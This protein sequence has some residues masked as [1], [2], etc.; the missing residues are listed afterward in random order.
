M[1]K[2]LTFFLRVVAKDNREED[3]TAPP[4]DEIEVK[5]ATAKTLDGLGEDGKLA[6]GVAEGGA[7]RGGL[8][9]GQG[10]LCV[11]PG[12][13]RKVEPGWDRE[14]QWDPTDATS[15]AKHPGCRGTQWGTKRAYQRS[16]LHPKTTGTT[17]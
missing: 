15:N 16:V 4:E 8:H 11:P 6:G 3:E 9:V 10:P 2:A 14:H 7:R 1:S 13:E 12:A 17:Q 5:E